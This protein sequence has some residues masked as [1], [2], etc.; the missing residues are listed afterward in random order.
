MDKASHVFSS[1][2]LQPST[3]DDD[4]D[5]DNLSLPFSGSR[6][7]VFF[8]S[9]AS[10]K[11]LML[12]CK[13]LGRYL[14]MNSSGLNEAVL[15]SRL[16]YTLGRRSTHAYRVSIVAS[17]AAELLQQLLATTASVVSKS[18]VT[19][20]NSRGQSPR[21][22]FVFSG[23]GAQYAQMGCDLLLR[24][25]LF[26]RAIEKASDHLLSLGSGWCLLDELRRSADGGSRIDEP[27]VSQP[28][29]TAIQI[30]LIHLLSDFGLQYCAVI[31]HSS[32]EI[33]AAYAVGAVSFEH[34]MAVA[35]FRGK[36]TSELL[37]GVAQAPGAMLAI[38]STPDLV[39]D[40]IDKL[41][42]ESDRMRIACFNSPRS[43]TVS[44]D[45]GAIEALK[46]ALTADSLFNRKLRTS[47]PLTIRI[48]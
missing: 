46:T 18:A 34:A 1:L 10:D 17:T 39:A 47:G 9:A 30:G 2:S 5:L 13:K 20:A 6:Q 29:T 8:L 38:G 16:A 12:L 7:L 41:S 33:A 48:R 28:A 44:G 26:L 25:P 15:L 24:Y 27:A 22:A 31:G 40:Y 4:A 3:P 14:V 19:G 43:V 36:V 35:Y 42:P 21:I 37:T 23:Q 11:S 45:D 32:G